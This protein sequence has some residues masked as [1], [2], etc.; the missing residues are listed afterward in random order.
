MFIRKRRGWEIPESQ[1]TPEHLAFGR[2]ALLAGAAVL[3]APIP[4]GAQEFNPGVRNMRYRPGRDITMER[5]ATT[6]NNYYEFGTDKGIHRTAE[7][8]PLR[9]WRVKLDG[10]VD[11]P[12]EYDIDEL[13]KTMPIEERVYRLRCVEAW[14]MVVPWNGFPLK[15][16]LDAA[17]PQSGAKYLRFETAALPGVMPGLRQSWYP[18]PYVEGCTI[19]EA[20]NDLSFMVVGAYGKPLLP[21]NGA[22]LRIH[23]P[24]KYGFKAGKS[25]VRITLTAERPKSFWEA[26]QPQEYG[27]W[28]NINPEVAHPRWSQ[29]S[30]RVLG[31]GERVPTQLFNGYG[32]FVADLYTGLQ[33]ERLWA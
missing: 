13:I 25:L 14:S 15:A 20:A 9:P 31:T 2:R 16:L 10:L 28:A 11:R 19:E 8:L 26:I 5:N 17:G 23:Q 24:W 30:E 29:A 21:Q 27:F 22:P 33:R 12:R 1:V 4:A 6:Y 32:E 18:W 7:R 3:A